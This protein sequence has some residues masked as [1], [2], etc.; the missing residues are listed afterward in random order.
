[1]KKVDLTLAKQLLGELE[2]A[3]ELADGLRSASD[4]NKNDYTVEMSKALGLVTGLLTESSMLI[5]DIT[6][7]TTD[8]TN[9]LPEQTT[10]SKLGSLL[11]GT[12][13]KGGFGG[14]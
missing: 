9:T 1:M 13:L 11:S 3:L 2:L 10:A 12:K 14:N 6:K 5:A 4:F 8:V 7:I